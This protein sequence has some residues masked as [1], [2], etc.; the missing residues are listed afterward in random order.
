M[1]NRL[2]T[3]NA[4]HEWL[5]NFSPK[6]IKMVGG[7]KGKVM[8]PFRTITPKDYSKLKHFSDCMKVEKKTRKSK[9]NK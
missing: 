4:W 7:V 9:I 3:R 6:P 5:I 1:K 2:L 8:S